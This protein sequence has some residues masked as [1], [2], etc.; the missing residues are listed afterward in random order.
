MRGLRKTYGGRDV[1]DGLDLQA[2]AGAV[3]AVLGPNGAGKT[4][5]VEC[6]EGLRSPDGGTV[7][8]LGLDPVADAAAL[9]PRVGVMLQDGGLPTGVRAMEMLRHVSRMYAAPRD[10]DELAERLGLHAF[11]RTAVRRL[12]GGQR[13]RLAL[14]AAVVGRPEVVFLDEPSAGMDPQSRHA[15]WDLVRELRADGVAVVLTT[16]LMDEAE[17]LADVVH[18][19]DHGRVIASGDVPH[20]LSDGASGSAPRVRFAARPGLPVG[21]LAA[22]LA[23]DLPDAGWSAVEAEPGEYVLAGPVAPA[24]LEAL[25]GWLAAQD[26][27]VTRL[28]VGRR[29]LEDVFLDLTGRHLR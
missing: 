3:T 7:R 2:T 17:D 13:Q 5:T 12:S 16:H 1:V 4:T 28:T 21:A 14:A 8:V 11:A 15:V 29:T 9:R 18:V 23:R 24:T 25:T 26:T 10:V 6:C 22:H 27:L 20:L 19:V